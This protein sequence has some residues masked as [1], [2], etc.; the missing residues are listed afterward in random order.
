MMSRLLDYCLCPPKKY[1]K[2]KKNLFV[3]ALLGLFFFF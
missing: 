3:F 1:K 2:K